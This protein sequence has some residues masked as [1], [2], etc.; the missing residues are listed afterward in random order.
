M[1]IINSSFNLDV[2][3]DA[4]FRDDQACVLVLAS[5]VVVNEV[6]V[7]FQKFLLYKQETISFTRYALCIKVYVTV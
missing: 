5:T 4:D 6:P 7:K 1:F 3:L 2:N